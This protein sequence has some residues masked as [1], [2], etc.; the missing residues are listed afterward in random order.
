MGHRMT[1]TYNKPEH[2]LKL[3]NEYFEMLEFY[4]GFENPHKTGGQDLW[5]LGKRE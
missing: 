4:D 3:V 5:I 1:T 2:F